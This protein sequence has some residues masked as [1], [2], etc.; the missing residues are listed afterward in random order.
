LPDERGPATVAG[1]SAGEIRRRAQLLL[2][3]PVARADLSLEFEPTVASGVDVHVGG[4]NFF[5]PMLQDIAGASSSVHVNQFGFR[6]GLVG[7]AF[8]E[9]LMEK[10]SA[11][12]RVRVVVDRQG[13]DP[14]RGSRSFYERLTASGVEV[15]VVRATQPR[16]PRGLLGSGEGNRWNL[17]QLGHIDHRKAIVVD[18]RIGW[19]GGAGFEDH[20]QDGRFHD[21]FLRATGP[22]VS[23]LQIV[24][25]ASFRWLGGAIDAA[26]VDVLFPVHDGDVDGVPAVVLHNAP[27]RSRPITDAIARLLDDARE[28]LDVVNP[29]VADRAMIRR[30]ERAG[31]RGVAVRLFVPAAANNWACASAQR[32]HH[33]TLLAAGVRIV[34]YPTM[35]HAKAFVRD[36][37]DVLAGTCNLEAWSLRRFFEIDLLVRSPDLARQFEERFAVP[38]EEVSTAGYALTDRRERLKAAAFARISPL[39]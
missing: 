21:L 4:T 10:A 35:L 20:F 9:A 12:V 38:A 32:Y 24:F 29:Y 16:A 2:T 3:R 27:G 26:E 28:T 19:V 5:P 8:A 34:E 30:I 31:K 36:G 13:S 7:D 23:Q 33:R 14:D 15:C 18:G 37:E 11:G 1:D 17:G 39:L 22:V 25:L 6:P